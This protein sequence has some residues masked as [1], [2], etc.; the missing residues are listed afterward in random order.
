MRTVV[1]TGRELMSLVD[2]ELATPQP[3]GHDLL[4]RV[5]AVSVNPIDT[6]RR[7]ALPADDPTPRVLGWD[8]AGVVEA[9][10]PEVSMFRPGDVVWWMG[11]VTRPGC[12]SEYQLVDERLVGHRPT[13][14]TA[15]QAAALPLT[16]LTAWEC[17]FERLHIDV[18]GAH[19]GTTVLVIN[20]AG[21][22][23]S[24][25]IQLAKLAG[26]HVIAT[27]S[28]PE[29][30]AWCRT[31]GAD[32]V[33]D[34]RTD[35]VAQVGRPVEYIAHFSSDLDRHWP[36]MTELVA[37]QGHLVSIVGNAGPLPMETLRA[38]SAS[39][40]W[41]LVFTRPRFQTADRVQHHHILSRL[42]RWC[43]E[44]RLQ[45]TARETLTPISALTLRRAHERLEAGTM[46]GKL[47]LQ[48][49]PPLRTGVP[50]EGGAIPS[51]SQRPS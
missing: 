29:S 20:G 47:V 23:G 43:D 26:L 14:W 16:A 5:E 13:T 2:V 34:H 7:I 4:M 17:L 22:V 21:G 3:T 48:G 40:A 28:R 32:E 39:L 45:G 6:K 49:W 44:G 30:A 50:P 46:I 15:A 42:A 11:D 36:A 9:V 19:R 1:H 33:I 12:N 25:G 18:A 24:I 37:P 27:A 8:A 10:G 51:P 38:K 35:L 31:M 41:E